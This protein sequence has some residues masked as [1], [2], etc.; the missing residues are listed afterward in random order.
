MRYMKYILL[1]SLVALTGLT[2]CAALLVGGASQ[3]G[4]ASVQERSIGDNLDD[5]SISTEINRLFAS[6]GK[7]LLKD[8]SVRVQ[9][10][11]VLLTGRTNRT[12]VALEAVR[13]AWLASGVHEVINEIEV[14]EKGTSLLN[15]TQDNINET[16]IEA[17]LL[18]TKGI[19]SVN[20]TIEVVNGVA[21]ILGIAQN[22]EERHN[23]AY[24]ASITKGIRRVVSYV[25]LR[26][27]PIR[28]GKIGNLRS[29]ET[30]A[31]VR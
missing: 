4:V 6:E 13:L 25:R 22:E 23:V 24:I 16:Q 3:V 15:Y 26:N 7:G 31:G 30:N 10:G 20:Y 27:D 5:S 8:V 29:K 11:R 19:R 14:G 28:L 9:E 21:Y 18:A 17:R 12:D 1:F 2:G